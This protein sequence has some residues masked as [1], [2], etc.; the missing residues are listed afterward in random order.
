VTRSLFH[1][2]PIITSKKRT[3]HPGDA[4]E[5]TAFNLGFEIV[6]FQTMLQSSLS[7]SLL[8]EDTTSGFLTSNSIR[9]VLF[10]ASY[11]RVDPCFTAGKQIAV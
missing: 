7:S 1:E 2:T 3:I 11:S 10:S 8:C 9:E 6:I 4:F 5:V